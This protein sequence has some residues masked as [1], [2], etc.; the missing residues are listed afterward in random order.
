VDRAHA[1]GL[2]V[3]LDVVYNHLGPDGNYLGEFSA[4]YFTD[5]YRTDWGRALNFDGPDAAPVRE[6]FVANAGYWIEEFHLDGLRLDA[7]QSIHDRSPEHVLAAIARRVRAAARGRGTI[8]VAENEPQD[9]RLLGS[10]EAG[11]HGLDALWNDDFHHSAMVALTAPRGLLQRSPG[12]AAGAAVGGQAGIPLS[13]A[14][15]QLAE[16]APRHPDG[17]HR[18]RALRRLPGEPRSARELGRGDRCHR[19][20]SPGRHRAMTALLLLMP[21][22]PM[23]FQ[24][25]EFFASSPFVYFADHAPALAARVREGR[26]EFLRQFPSLAAPE[27]ARR[28]PDPGDPATFHRC[29]LDLRGRG[30]HAEAYALHRDLLTLRRT[31]PVFRA[32]RPGG[33][34][35]AGARR[36]RPP[37]LRGGGDDR[38]LLVNLAADLELDA[39]PEPLLAPP[40]GRNWQTIWTS[41]DPRYGGTGAPTPRGRRVEH[42]GR[43]GVRAGAHP[44]PAARQG[45]GAAGRAASA[46]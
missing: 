44:T 11:G 30:R 13:G 40:P 41:E 15:V 38:L 35:G 19:L 22:T 39:M 1:L 36:A 25:Q 27:V 45:N 7:T 8:L 3:I 26:A 28:I 43:G 23:L 24:G 42:R 4:D 32:Q 2:G 6:F 9:V 5:R 18:A 46:H 21:A 10:P 37:V 33:V 20:T 31:D 12:D 17:R 34:D 16:A 29:K 14:V